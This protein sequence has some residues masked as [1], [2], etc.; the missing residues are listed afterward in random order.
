MKAKLGNEQWR[1]SGRE[2]QKRPGNLRSWGY[3]WSS[4]HPWGWF[5]PE[6]MCQ[7]HSLH[8][9]AIFSGVSIA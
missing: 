6:L 5:A 3:P 4:V 7:A 1:A 2:R 8:A 9:Y